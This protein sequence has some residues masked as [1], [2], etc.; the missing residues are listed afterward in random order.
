MDEVI[1]RN[2]ESAQYVYAAKKNFKIEDK[3]SE[4]SSNIF[5]AHFSD[6]H[7]D[8]PRY[9]NVIKLIE[10]FKAEFAIHTG[11]TVCWDM[12]DNYAF[13]AEG[14]NACNVPI[15][16]C[17]G[18]H[19]TTCGDRKIPNEELHKLLITSIKNPIQAEYERGYY[20]VDFEGK[21]LRLIVLNCYDFDNP[22]DDRRGVYSFSQ[23][24]CEWLV[25]VLKESKG[26]EYA[27]IIA[28]HEG[29]VVEPNSNDYGFCQRF[30]PHPW[31]KGTSH[32]PLIA[33]IIDAFKHGKPLHIDHVWACTKQEV[34]ID[35]A[36]EGNGEFIC[37]LGGH[38][39]SDLVGYLPEYP[40]QL[41]IHIPSSACFPAGYH[42][43]G[44]E[45]SDL[46]RIPDTVTEDCINFYGI[47]RTK[48]TISIVRV[49]ATVNDLMKKR[50]ALVLNYE[51]INRQK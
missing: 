3:I 36:F 49:G 8:I 33:E 40:D 44:E 9:E 43:I 12:L 16:N 14:A 22:A 41:S 48:K 7:S 4:S 28:A 18:N 21:R 45:L 29:D 23:Q 42:N 50:Q 2:M 17:I 32:R 26:K 39:H 11:D 37:Y 30:Y 47:N 13:L 31:G 6:M 27:V 38:F 20:Y 10:Y 24:Q 34:K 1:L 25:R 51:G 19:D 35:D 5:F 46:P 15:Y